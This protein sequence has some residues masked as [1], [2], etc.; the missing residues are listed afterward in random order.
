[1]VVH[2]LPP[3]LTLDGREIAGKIVWVLHAVTIL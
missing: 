2:S 1:V 3:F